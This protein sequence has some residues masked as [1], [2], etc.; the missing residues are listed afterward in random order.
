MTD[1]KPVL[2]GVDD[3]ADQDALVRY[4]AHQAALRAVPLHVVHAVRQPS[5]LGD[6]AEKDAEARAAVRRS[7]ALVDDFE[8]IARSA[9]PDIV[10]AGELPLGDPAGTLVERSAA[11]SLVVLAH[12]GG[13]GFPRLPLG[14]V[15]L[16]VATHAECPVLVT[17]PG[18]D[19]GPPSNVVVA[20]VD[21]V[22]FRPEAL[23]F[24]FAEAARRTAR[25]EV[26]H[27]M[28]RPPLLPGHS[29]MDESTASESENSARRFLTG[30]IAEFA[31]RY[32]EV[33]V[34]LR[35]DWGAHPAT[36]LTELSRK[37]DVLV[38]G[39]RG[40]AGLRTLLLGSVTNEV[41]HTAQ[42]PVAVVPG[43][44]REGRRS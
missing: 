11:A 7:A 31:G 38:V 27:A 14:S 24:A 29:G 36:N 13:G 26:V 8:A 43:P 2:V 12:R 4:A 39:S 44:T 6:A 16:H 41:L 22:H 42:C 1:A 34:G 3:A 9:F 32:P 10:V 33:R 21:I 18:R 28:Y 40:R 20:G 37:A 5:P 35:I 25:L 30:Q 17:R 23:D 15:S 19:A